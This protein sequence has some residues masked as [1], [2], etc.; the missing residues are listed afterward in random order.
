M[1]SEKAARRAAPDP[2]FTGICARCGHHRSMHRDPAEG[3]GSCFGEK[4]PGRA[5]LCGCRGFEPIREKRAT[6]EKPLK[7][8]W[9]ARILRLG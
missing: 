6:S 8:G 5:A 1:M 4:R 9:L 2:S 3:S 7:R